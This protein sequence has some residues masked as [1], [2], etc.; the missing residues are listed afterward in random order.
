MLVIKMRHYQ[1]ILNELNSI[2]FWWSK[3]SDTSPLV[4]L[5]VGHTRHSRQTAMLFCRLGYRSLGG[6]AAQASDAICD[7]RYRWLLLTD[8]KF[9]GYSIIVDRFYDRCVEVGVG[10]CAVILSVRSTWVVVKTVR[11]GMPG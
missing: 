1:A 10:Y 8:G 11:A 6:P 5:N 4:V 9:Y 2:M 7:V 3:N